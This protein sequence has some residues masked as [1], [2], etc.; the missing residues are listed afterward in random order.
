[1]ANNKQLVKNGIYNFIQFIINFGISFFLTPYL[2]KNVGKEAYS[3]FPLVNNMIGYTSVITTAVGGMAGR[4]ITIRFYKG[5]FEGANCYFNTVLVANWILSAFFTVLSIFFIVY[6]PAVLN[7]PT[8]LEL[9]IKVLFAFSCAVLLMGLSTGILNVGTFIKN[10]IDVIASVKVVSNLLRVGLILLLFSIFEPSIIYMSA[11]AF[12]AALL[13]VFFNIKFKSKFLPELNVNPR[14]YFKIGYLKELLS[15]SVWNSV[16]QLSV[17]ILTQLDLLITN[18]FIGVEEAADFSLAKTIPMLIQSVIAVLV[19]VYMPQ[20]TILFAKGKRT[21]LVGEINKSIIVMS[22]VT[23]LPIGFLIIFNND[24]FSL[25]IHEQSSSRITTL[26][27]LSLLPM[28]V[29]CGMNTLFNVFTVTN[30]LKIPSLVLLFN[31][32]LNVVLLIV[33]L[34][35]TSWGV[36]AIPI[37]SLTTLV[38]KNLTFTPMYAAKCLNLPLTTFYHKILLGI[39]SIGVVL[40]VGYVVR[41]LISPSNWLLF[42][43]SGFITSLLSIIVCAFIFFNKDER[44]YLFNSVR[45]KIFNF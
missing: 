12:G 9:S 7:I 22:I 26:S 25:W 39:S 35:F 45:S 44:E 33:A 17:L 32:L 14:R 16:N 8:H 27:I 19:G 15:S 11:S 24:F 20:F 37:I 4:F 3:F 1:M 23:A 6:L 5:D 2:I 21:E 41:L 36:Y 13:D 42:I 40:I 30:H 31:G 29:S 34:H 38:T 28:I 10:R 43:V 18:I